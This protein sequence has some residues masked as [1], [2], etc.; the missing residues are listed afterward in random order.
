M[1]FFS[2]KVAT[3][4]R[5]PDAIHDPVE[6]LIQEIGQEFLE[7]ARSHQ[8]G[9]L[10]SRFWSDKLMDWAMKDEAFKVQL[11]RFVDVF[12]MLPTPE[13]GHEPLAAYFSQPSEKP[14]AG[15]DLGMRAGGLL[16]GAFASTVTGQIEST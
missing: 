4:R 16:K 10:S 14:P 13:A 12:P 7:Q 3:P 2:R 1:S 6:R 5:A 15:L 8:R 11:F 9:L